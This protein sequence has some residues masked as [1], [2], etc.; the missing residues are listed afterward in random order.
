M[1]IIWQGRSGNWDE[2]GVGAIFAD[3]ID[4]V[5]FIVNHDCDAGWENAGGQQA[6]SQVLQTIG[7]FE[8]EGRHGTR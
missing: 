3:L 7:A 2:A 6:F 4:V 8:A 5:D 1:V